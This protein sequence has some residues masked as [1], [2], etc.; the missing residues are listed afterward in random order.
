[1]SELKI[2]RKIRSGKKEVD[3]YLE[4]ME[5]HLLNMRS[6]NTLKLVLKLDEINGEIVNDL[7]KII[8]GTDE[9]IITK[10]NKDPKKPPTEEKVSN[11]KVLDDSSASKLFDRIMLLYTKVKDI[12]AITDIMNSMTPEEIEEAKKEVL[13]PEGNIFEHAQ[14]L[15]TSKR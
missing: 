8:E 6:S 2:N 14:K 12:K 7:N 1:M 15:A 5:D 10:P 3:E 9:T 13:V 4:K 11:L